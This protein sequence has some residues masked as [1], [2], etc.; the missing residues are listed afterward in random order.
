MP[1]AAA[2]AR[3]S[4]VKTT[5]ERVDDITVKLSVTVEADRVRRALDEA[6][7]KLAQEVRVPGFRP[8]KAPR[9][10]LEQRLGKDA[11]VQEALRDALPDFYAEA[12]RDAD[13]AAVGPPELDV[14]T[15]EEGQDAVFTA[16]VEILPEVELPDVGAIQIPHPEWEVTDEEVDAR[17]DDL[18][19]RFAE[20]DTVKRPVQA[21]DYVRISITGSRH[22]EKVDDASADDILYEVGEAR[23][24]GPELDRVLPGTEAGAILKFNDTLGDD[25]GELAGQ[26]LAFTAIVKEVKAKRLP[27]LDDDFAIT[28]SEFDT[29]DEL[30]DDLRLQL[31]RE[32]LLLA[33]QALRARVVETIADQVE[34]PIPKALVTEEA[35]FRLG[36]LAQQVEAHGLTLEQYFESAGLKP[37]QVFEQFQQEAQATVKAR[38]VVDAVARQ[39]EIGIEPDD[40]GMEIGRQAVRLGQDADEL[41][42]FIT[43][44]PNRVGMLASDA[45][46]RKAIDHLV[47][48]VQVLSG[49]PDGLAEELWPDDD[50]PEAGETE[51]G[52]AGDDD[53]GIVGDSTDQEQQR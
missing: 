1:L 38:L 45:L 51:T 29:I 37:Q 16:T 18:R 21:G 49:P 14:D 44:D 2:T 31:Q 25:Y 52:D 47:E 48:A 46:R 35:R 43:A 6:S 4:L 50:E 10:L 12:L 17:L 39:A 11:V 15:F 7:R 30:R 19:E 23:D 22:G 28:A 34:V 5:I 41:A 24:D 26:E 36:R 33:Q 8:G 3:E 27:A 20:L 32:K 42:E 40:L 9:R 13:V 53:S